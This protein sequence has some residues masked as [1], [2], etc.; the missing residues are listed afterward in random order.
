M[1]MRLLYPVVGSILKLAII[2]MYSVDTSDQLQP[3]G[4]SFVTITKIRIF[5]SEYPVTVYFN[6]APTIQYFNSILNC[7]MILKSKTI[8]IT[9]FNYSS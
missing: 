6:N 5:F 4:M 7:G 3:Y 8:L 1:I 9:T 2:E